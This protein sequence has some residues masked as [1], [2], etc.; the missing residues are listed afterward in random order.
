MSNVDNK[1]EV[2]PAGQVAKLVSWLPSVSAAVILIF[3]AV[4]LLKMFDLAATVSDDKQWGRLLFLYNGLEALAFAA[5]GVLL[6]ERVQ[7]SRALA[8]ENRADASEAKADDAQQDAAQ[9][10]ANGKA[11]KKAVESKVRSSGALESAT[12]AP[13][14][15]ELSD[16][17]NTLFPD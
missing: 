10:T 16:L 1:G 15:A 2:R 5:A 13:E 11:L 17:A 9:A 7:R 8:A 4:L 6:G 3:F 14:L 12:A